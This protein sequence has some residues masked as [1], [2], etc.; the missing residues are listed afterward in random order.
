MP[1]VEY[2]LR[3]GAAGADWY[4]IVTGQRIADALG[5]DESRVV[6]LFKAASHEA[7]SAVLAV[8]QCMV[9]TTHAGPAGTPGDVM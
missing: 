2:L 7:R 9:S 5:P 4:W 1:S 3:I 6:D 8:L